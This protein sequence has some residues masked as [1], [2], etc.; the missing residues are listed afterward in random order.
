MNVSTIEK[1]GKN[2]YTNTAHA[3]STTTTAVAEILH[4]T[5]IHTQHPETILIS[6]YY[7]YGNCLCVDSVWCLEIWLSPPPVLFSFFSLSFR[8]VGRPISFVRVFSFSRR[9]Q[10][11][12]PPNCVCLSLSLFNWVHLNSFRYWFLFL[13]FFYSLCRHAYLHM[14]CLTF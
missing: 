5:S 1:Q 4:A 10:I 7:T 3:Q 13:F 8:L 14:S 9:W 2:I 12:S 6:L 11:D